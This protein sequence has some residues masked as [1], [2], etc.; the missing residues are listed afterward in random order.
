[1]AKGVK[2]GGILSETLHRC[3]RHSCLGGMRVRKRPTI[4]MRGLVAI[5]LLIGFLRANAQSNPKQEDSNLDPVQT[6]WDKTEKYFIVVAVSQYST[7]SADLA[8]AAV[9]G[10]EVAAALQAAGYQPIGSTGV[11]QHDDATRENF[12]DLLTGVQNKTENSHVIIYYSGHAVADSAGRNLWLQMFGQKTL[13]A[14]HGI[15]VTEIVDAVRESYPGQLALVIDSCFSGQGV[16]ASS[17]TLKD[18]GLTTSIFTSSSSVQESQK[19]TVG[20]LEMSAFT[21]ALTQG[22]GAD[23]DNADQDKDG[24]LTFV[25]LERYTRAML[26]KWAKDGKIR[27]RMTPFLLQ[28]FQMVLSYNGKKATNTKGNERDLID[29]EEMAATLSTAD[30]LTRIGSAGPAFQYPAPVPLAKQIASRIPRTADSYTLALKAIAEGRGTESVSLLDKATREH[31][32]AQKLARARAWANLYSGKYEESAY[33]YEKALALSDMSH[34]PLMLETANALALAGK[35]ADAE[36]L[37]RDVIKLSPKDSR[38]LVTV[39]TN[40]LATVY[41]ARKDW[42]KANPLYEQLLSSA[43]ELKVNSPLDVATISSNLAYVYRGL[44]KADEADRLDLEATTVRGAYETEQHS[45]IAADRGPADVS[46]GSGMKGGRKRTITGCLMKGDEADEFTLAGSDGS[47]WELS[48]SKSRVD[49]SNHVGHAISATGVVSHTKMD[50]MKEDAKTEAKDTGMTNSNHGHL[51]VTDVQMV[52][53][54][55]QK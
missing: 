32:S 6:A 55:C 34:R 54:S 47:T 15:S 46:G 52:S 16:L 19:I 31:I 11:L 27:D 10:T 9:D 30:K 37:Y 39:A 33:W 49:L 51:A 36:L 1:M 4:F 18:L 5:L 22:L 53:E 43:K 12:I 21:Y 42:D 48:S 2:S 20:T 3:V 7:S 29:S 44:G 24:V 26:R 40:N 8:F 35:T 17:L 45:Q 14:H 28:N 41:A 50:N 23:W 38:L 25:E 13:G